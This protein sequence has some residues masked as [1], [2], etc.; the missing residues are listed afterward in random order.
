[1]TV[2]AP[3]DFEALARTMGRALDLP[4]TEETLPGVAM[5][6]ALAWRLAPDF[7]DFPVPDTLEPAA[8]FD[9]RPGPVATP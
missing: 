3:P 6:L 7:L 9:P 8:V 2:S 5:N 4:L 1:M